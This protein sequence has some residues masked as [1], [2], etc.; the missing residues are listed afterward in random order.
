MIRRSADD[1]AGYVFYL[2]KRDI[3]DRILSMELSRCFC[4]WAA[5]GWRE[6]R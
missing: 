6:S 3:E 4:I 1:K 5:R 2:P